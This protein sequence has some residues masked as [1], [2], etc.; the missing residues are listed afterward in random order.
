MRAALKHSRLYIC[1]SLLSLRTLTLD[2]LGIAWCYRTTALWGDS[3]LVVQRSYKV[4]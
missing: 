1:S 3:R 2:V 4:T